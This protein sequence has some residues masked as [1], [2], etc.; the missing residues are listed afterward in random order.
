M[1]AKQGFHWKIVEN[2]PDNWEKLHLLIKSVNTNDHSTRDKYWDKGDLIINLLI[3]MFP[4]LVRYMDPI[5]TLS[6][7]KTSKKKEIMDKVEKNMIKKD[8]LNI[9]FDKN[10]KPLTTTFS[11]DATFDIMIFLWNFFLQQKTNISKIVLLDAV[12]SLNRIMEEDRDLLMRIDVLWQ[13]MNRLKID[14][15]SMIDEEMY[16]LLFQNPIFLIESFA[17]KKKKSIKLYPEQE[18]IIK[19]IATSI[20]LD[21]PILMGNQMPTGTGKSFLCVPLAQKIA[22]L[23]RNKTILFACSNE[24]VNIDIASTALLGDDLHL[25][26]SSLIRD[27]LGKTRVLL[28]PHKRCFPAKWKLVYKEESE[29]KTGSIVEQWHFYTQKTGKNPDII[30]SDL[31][32][33]FELLKSSKELGEPFIAYIDEFISDAQSNQMMAKICRFLPKHS[34]LLSAILP[35]FESMDKLVG[36]FCRKYDCLP[37][38]CLYRVETCNVPITCAVIDQDGRL[39]MPHHLIKNQDDL[40]LLIAEMRTNPRIRRCYTAKHVYY[41][42]QNLDDILMQYNLGFIKLFDNIGKIQNNNVINYAIQILEFLLDHFEY[43]EKFKDYKPIIMDPPDKNKVFKEQSHFYEGKTLFISND[44]FQH[45]YEASKDLFEPH[46]RWSH[47]VEMIK[48]NRQVKEQKIMKLL[49]TKISKGNSSGF[50]RLEKEKKLSE[51]SEMQTTEYLPAK[52][53]I[54]SKDHFYRYHPK[55]TS[56]RFIE[57]FPIDLPD[58]F[59]ESFADME[60]LLFSAGIGFYDKNKMTQHQRNLMMSIYKDLCFIDSCKDIVFGTNLPDLINVFITKDFAL[61]ESVPIL[62]QLMGRVGRIGRSYH[63]NII[64]DDEESVCK[65]LSLDANIDN[66][67]VVQLMDHFDDSCAQD[68]LFQT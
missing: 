43:L 28:R 1:N 65:I 54:N 58:V 56:I 44:T 42:S 7:T 31:E 61:T 39:R 40:R 21:E 10:L 57:R 37:N 48:K 30:V 8:L 33:C 63:A 26:L 24:L 22:S 18:K 49:N 67:D 64:L 16:S 12:I 9:R 46:L 60:N 32:A 17:N 66:Q 23:K 27:D 4:D 3:E 25:W 51:I 45:V 5:P 11:I 6:T 59:N 29:S 2:K 20:I 50:T 14:M 19:K 35:K 47:I 38:E 62:Y 15:N 55:D 53:V 52:F 34:I 68:D 13:A 41:W 36:F